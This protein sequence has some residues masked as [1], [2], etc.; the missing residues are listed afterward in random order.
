MT[1]KKVKFRDGLYQWPEDLDIECLHK[2][3]SA[4]K[5]V[6]ERNYSTGYSSQEVFLIFLRNKNFSL[7]QK[8]KVEHSGRK[9]EQLIF[10]HLR[11]VRKENMERLVWWIKRE[12]N[13]P[14]ASRGTNLQEGMDWKSKRSSQWWRKIQYEYWSMLS[15]ID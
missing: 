7:T 15:P 8:S 13:D 5:Y 3:K 12:Q 4:C 1:S 6:S 10:S 14:K 2:Q 9:K 11:S